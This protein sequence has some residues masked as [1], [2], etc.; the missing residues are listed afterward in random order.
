MKGAR[1]MEV[2]LSICQ[3][4]YNR[5]KDNFLSELHKLALHT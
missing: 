3:S 4:L 1:T 5:D 2:L